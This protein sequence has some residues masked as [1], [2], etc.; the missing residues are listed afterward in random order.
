MQKSYI[1][2]PQL[3][4][5]NL[6]FGYTLLEWGV[7]VLLFIFAICG[8]YFIKLNAAFFIPLITMLLLL[9]RYNGTHNIAS[10]LRQILRYFIW[11]QQM[12]YSEKERSVFFEKTKR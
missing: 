4:R 11:E 9:W 2:P 5:S 1:I 7:M 12:Y 8:L 10:L 3:R 6:L